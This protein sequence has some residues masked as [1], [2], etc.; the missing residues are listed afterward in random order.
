MYMEAVLIK[1]N[2]KRVV[3]LL[4]RKMDN[5]C[6][7]RQTIISFKFSTTLL[8]FDDIANLSAKYIICYWFDC[9]FLTVLTV[10][11]QFTN[12]FV[13]I[14]LER[15]LSI[16][17]STDIMAYKHIVKSKHEK[18]GKFKYSKLYL[19]LHSSTSIT[20]KLW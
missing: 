5:R 4:D 14:E 7:S 19:I 6:A 1:S 15:L 10:Y 8:F 3:P 17:K 12:V 18:Q 16:K 20:L 9:Y 11:I 2:K 13:S